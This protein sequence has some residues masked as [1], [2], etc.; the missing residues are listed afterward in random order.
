MEREEGKSETEMARMVIGEV[1]LVTV[2]TEGS[3]SCFPG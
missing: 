1:C 3:G 2:L